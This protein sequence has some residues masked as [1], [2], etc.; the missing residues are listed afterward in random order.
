MVTPSSAITKST[1]L[2]SQLCSRV[3]LR[4]D[5]ITVPSLSCHL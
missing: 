4:L 1:S 5:L 3:E 2:C